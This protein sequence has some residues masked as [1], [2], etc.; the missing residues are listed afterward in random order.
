MSA[1]LFSLSVDGMVNC[2]MIICHL[3]HA[4]VMKKSFLDSFGS[5]VD[6]RDKMKVHRSI[7]SLM[8]KFMFVIIL[9]V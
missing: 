4:F 5:C 2:V 7:N 8:H 3:M 1:I 9:K 6:P